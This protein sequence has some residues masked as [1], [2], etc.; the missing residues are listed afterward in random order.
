MRLQE[1]TRRV[2]EERGMSWTRDVK[3]RGTLGGTPYSG[4]S[5]YIAYEYT[6][7]GHR[8]KHTWD[9]H[10][11]NV[12]EGL[13]E[14]WTLLR[15]VCMHMHSRTLGSITHS[16]SSSGCCTSG[17]RLTFVFTRQR[18]VVSLARGRD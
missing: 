18:R 2:R 7:K 10:D 16:C 11:V 1:R 12:G 9:L 6:Q 13:A 8:E 15:G 3:G 4:W 17:I 5:C 14:N